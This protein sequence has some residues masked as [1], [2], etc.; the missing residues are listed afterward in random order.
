[1]IP[2]R[3]FF[4]SHSVPELNHTPLP[5]CMALREIPFRYILPVKNTP[6]APRSAVGACMLRGSRLS[7]FDNRAERKF[8]SSVAT[9]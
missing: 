7:I 6:I 1:M 2:K 3:L 4:T 9:V 5:T 8:T